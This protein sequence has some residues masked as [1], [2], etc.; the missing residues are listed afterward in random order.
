MNHTPWI[1]TPENSRPIIS[2]AI[3]N[4]LNLNR[5]SILLLAS[6]YLTG[7][8]HAQSPDTTAAAK[9]IPQLMESG[10]IP[11]LSAAVISK[12]RVVW[13]FSHG[14]LNDSLQTPVGRN[15]IFP[16]ASLSKPV[17]G[18][19]LMRLA[20]RG[21]FDL[22]KPLSELLEYPRI[23]HD[24]RHVKITARMVLSHGTGLPNWG[25]ER[26]ELNFDP[27]EGFNYSGEGFVYLQ[28]AVEKVTGL[29]LEE[30]ARREV[31]EPLGMSR[32][33]F[34]WQEQFEGDAV[35]G[36][37]WAWQVAHLPRYSEPNA[38]YSLLTTAEDY[39]RFVAAILNSTGLDPAYR[40][41]MLS[42]ARPANR[43]DRATPADDRVFWGLGWGLEKGSEG[44]AFWHWG[45]NGPFKAFI[46]ANPGNGAG[47]VYFANSNDG[48]SIAGD[49]T[50]LVFE[51]EHPALQ[52]VNYTRHDDPRR[53]LMKKL[54][55]SAV[56]K[57]GSALLESYNSLRERPENRLDIDEA[58]RFANFLTSN[59]LDS[60][61]IGVLALAV[62]DYPDS[63]RVYDRLAE[64]LLGTGAYEEAI[65]AHN[66]SLEIAPDNDN[67]LKRIEWINR[68]IAA[69]EQPVVLTKE[70]LQR[71][72][73]KYGPR[74]VR[75]ENGRLYYRREGNPE[76]P[77]TPLAED[78]FA[79]E[80]LETF[81]VRFELE[82]TG[83]SPRIIGLYI[84]GET[85]ESSRQ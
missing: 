4:R 45:D 2:P 55:G 47:I 48:L 50:S 83:P 14:T 38:A 3:G 81:R 21:E 7:P 46:V 65:A 71:C 15:T 58:G 51:G 41:E 70:Q 30:L 84:N 35:Y 24:A 40:K 62:K 9:A 80:G 53:K 27:G 72:A 22:D 85:D 56:K 32:S 10:D 26:L 25:G 17:F 61:A 73:G 68:R 18:Y 12:G 57:G 67:T 1:E 37:N 63:A 19:I 76:Y 64:A 44:T 8:L 74:L 16:A 43:P 28:K 5:F 23:A 82:G 33:S 6:V 66:R 60:A 20:A 29:T 34:V 79:L 36:K 69:K 52:W 39:G 59:R 75:L 13:T 11:G 78:L 54:E 49:M 31:F 42:P 77:L